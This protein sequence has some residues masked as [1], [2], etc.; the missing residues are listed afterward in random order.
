MSIEIKRDEYKYSLYVQVVGIKIANYI[1]SKMH[2][3]VKK[4]NIS[5][6]VEYNIVSRIRKWNNFDP[7]HLKLTLIFSLFFCF[8][9]VGFSCIN[10]HAQ[11]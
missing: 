5:R 11:I 7:S 4:V 10:I 8:L 2:A 3:D 9:F 1:V 6:L